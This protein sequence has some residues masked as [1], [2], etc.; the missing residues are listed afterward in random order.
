M[1]LAISEVHPHKPWSHAHLSIIGSTFLFESII[2]HAALVHCPELGGCLLCIVSTGI[3]VGTFM[4]IC[5][6]EGTL[7]CIYLLSMLYTR[8]IFVVNYKSI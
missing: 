1:L 5:Y 8:D 4:V 3:V 2:P 6:A 7:L